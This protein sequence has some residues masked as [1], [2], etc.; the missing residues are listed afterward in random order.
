MLMAARILTSFSHGAFF[1]VGLVVAAGLVPA[2]RRAG[3][4][5]AKFM[6]LTIAN[7]SVCRRPPG[8]ARSWAGARRFGAY[9][10]SA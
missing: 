9:R 1:G 7:S 5:A 6:G 10:H 8:P 3:A 2:E 4:I